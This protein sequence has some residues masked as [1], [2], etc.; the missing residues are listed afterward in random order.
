MPEDR[1]A[2]RKTAKYLAEGPVSRPGKIIALSKL[3]DNVCSVT[4]TAKG[5]VATLRRVA[6]RPSKPVQTSLFG[7]SLSG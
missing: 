1:H 3:D 2:V 7:R 6:T 4:K 5:R